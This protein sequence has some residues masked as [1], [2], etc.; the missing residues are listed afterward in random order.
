MKKLFPLLVLLSLALVVV[1][2]LVVSAQI[3]PQDC[4]YIKRL[5]V[6]GTSTAYATYTDP[7]QCAANTIAGPPV[8]GTCNL[9]AIS[10]FSEKWGLICTLNMI[11]IIV[12]WVF[13]VLVAIS[14]LLAILGAYYILTA[15]GDPGKVSTGRMYAIYMVIGLIIAL[16]ARAVPSIAKAALGY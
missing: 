13:I 16:I 2:P 4:C 11:N 5:I 10:C 1:L 9:G 8:G 15:G 7:G 6:Y 12:D 14:V 3:T